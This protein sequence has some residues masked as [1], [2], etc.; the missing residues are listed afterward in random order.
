[1]TVDWLWD[2]L[3]ARATASPDLPVALDE[4]DVEL[5][6]A[7]LAQRAGDTAGALAAA[8]VGSGTRVVWQLPTW[9]DALVVTAALSRLGAVQVPLLPIYRER[10]VRVVLRQVEPLAVIAPSTWRG[11][12]YTAMYDA[13]IPEGS[14][15]RLLTL[16]RGEPGAPAPF[17][18][19]PDPATPG[20]GAGGVPSLDD[21]RPAEG[22]VRWIF[23]TSGTTA[24]PKGAL[25]TDA[26]VAA[27][28]RAFCDRVR[29]DRSDRY[30]IVFPL[31]HVGGIGTVV[32]QMLTGAAALLDEQFDPV[33]TI[34]RLAAQG[35]TIG[36]GG[37]P[38]VQL[39]LDHQRRRPG[40]ALF[41]RLRVCLTGAAPKPPSLHDAVRAEMGGRGCISTYGLTEAPFA[42]MSDVDD[43]DD[44]LA[45]TE[46]RAAAGAVLR[47]VGDDGRDVPAGEVGEVLLRG[48]QVCRGYLDAS[49]DG[50]A[51]DV[52]G[53]LRTG[54]LGS[55]DDRGNLTIHGRKK[56]V[57]IRRGENISAKEVED[58]LVL[59]AALREVAVVGMPDERT[60]ERCCAVVVVRD[61]SPP[62]S[63]A[64]IAS[65]CAEH[66]LA[67]QKS[68]EQLE[69]VAALPRN[70]AGKVLK[71]ELQAQLAT[72][73]HPAP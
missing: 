57:I 22:D 47:I 30:P 15:A 56:D 68:P 27:G 5:S 36:A 71:H 49:L 24:D 65:F 13:S 53:F 11:F 37:T 4:R 46:G 17:V 31:T 63:L 52:A 18:A 73:R 45:A 21:A 32:A 48:P 26:S 6:F 62:P 44:D 38:L 12:D 61:G 59:H 72:A 43:L 3:E 7:Q 60:G 35:V 14:G 25:H 9:L 8:G 16:D 69:V 64:E 33:R 50:D 20:S 67:R 66:G 51:F 34:P 29:L 10:E 58:V 19:T 42:T 40:V 2:L 28:P 39:Y 1:V 41:P 54:D 55:L 70:A 23:F